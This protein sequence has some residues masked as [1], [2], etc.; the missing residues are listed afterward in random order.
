MYVHN[1]EGNSA[2]RVTVG[3]KLEIA[4]SIISLFTYLQT[5]IFISEPPVRPNFSCSFISHISSDSQEISITWSSFFNNEHL[6]ERYKIVVSP[7][8]SFCSSDHVPPGRP[9]RC[10]GLTTGIE[11]LFNISAINC[12]HIEGE[13]DVFLLQLQCMACDVCWWLGKG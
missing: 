7:D 3:D 12:E 5:I 11:Y 10:S 9:Y 13:A 8:P 6:V 1:I 2:H 4:V